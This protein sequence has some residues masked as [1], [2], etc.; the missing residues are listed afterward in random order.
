MSQEAIVDI[1]KLFDEAFKEVW[2]EDAKPVNTPLAAHF[3]LPT[4]QSR[5]R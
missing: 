1:Q 4:A 5:A 3:R 2:P